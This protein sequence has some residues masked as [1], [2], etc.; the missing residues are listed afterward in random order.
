MNVDI[1]YRAKFVIFNQNKPFL[2]SSELLQ[3]I[4]FSRF[5]VYWIQKHRQCKYMYKYEIW[6]LL[7]TLRLHML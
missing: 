5:D 3:K 4:W 7:K 2:E 6:I 1:V